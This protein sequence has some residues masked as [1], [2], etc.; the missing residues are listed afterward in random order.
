MVLLVFLAVV[1]VIAGTALVRAYA[2]LD[3]DLRRWARAHSLLVTAENRPMVHW[4]L[5]NARVLRTC[6][7]LAGFLLP[8]LAAV[9][10]GSP[11]AGAVHL[12]WVFVGYL[13][14]ALYAELSLVRPLPA[15]RRAATLVPRALEDYLPRELRITQRSLGAVIAAASL[16]L[17]AV[18]FASDSMLAP[19]LWLVPL[20]MI[21]GPALAVGLERL[22]GWLVRRPQP[23]TDP[24]LLAA[25]DAIRAQSVHS[26]SG[27]GIAIELVWLSAVCFSLAQSDVQFLRW[28]MWVPGLFGLSAALFACQYYGHRAWRVRRH[29]PMP[30][31]RAASA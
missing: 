30:A 13:L 6:G 31:E 27:S 10:F 29:L 3:E 14:G 16:V 19:E 20:G 5:R 23:F 4:Y 8:Y 2:G 1:G 18:P 28:T 11:G 22:Q 15:G 7:A 17:L 26:V 9:A 24:D 12:V 25:D 21:G